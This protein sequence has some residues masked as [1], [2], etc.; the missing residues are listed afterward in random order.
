[1]FYSVLKHVLYNRNMVD[2]FFFSPV[3]LPHQRVTL[4]ITGHVAPWVRFGQII[5]LVFPPNWFFSIN[6]EE[7]ASLEWT[8]AYTGTV[9][10]LNPTRR[11]CHPHRSTADWRFTVYVGWHAGNL[12]YAPLAASSVCSRLVIEKKLIKLYGSVKMLTEWYGY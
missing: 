6:E 12:I 1:M 7:F 2:Q 10:L 3:E 9:H 4:V 8:T 11:H 5:S